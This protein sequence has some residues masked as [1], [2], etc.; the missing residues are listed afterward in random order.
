MSQYAFYFDQARCGACNCC[1]VA[2]K[3]WNQL[4]PGLVNWRIQF[5]YEADTSP[6][7]FPL[8]MGCNH[9]E[10]PACLTACAAAAITK[11]EA[12]GAVYVDRNKCQELRSCITACPFAKPQ[13]A[14]DKQEPTK[15]SSWIVSHPMQKCDMCAERRERGDKPICVT[16]CIGRALDFGLA[17]DIQAMHPGAV[18]LNKTEF[19][20]AYKNNVPDDT[21]PSFF[22]KPKPA[23]ALNVSSIASTYTGKP[24]TI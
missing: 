2:C 7:F 9:C 11:D 14:D 21:K 17:T 12:S 6:F 15:R 19:S 16:S 18:R 5:T 1:T 10:N 4:N 8:S 22:I 13:I 23:S 24:K 3:D 20:Y